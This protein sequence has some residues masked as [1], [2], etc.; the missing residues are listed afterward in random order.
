VVGGG[1]GGEGEESG[2]GRKGRE[3]GMEAKIRIMLI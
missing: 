2:R 1:G 3:E